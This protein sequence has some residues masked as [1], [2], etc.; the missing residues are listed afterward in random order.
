MKILELIY[1][2]ISERGEILFRETFFQYQLSVCN[3][4]ILLTDLRTDNGIINLYPGCTFIYTQL[5][6]KYS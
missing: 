2:L 5:Q 3:D 1:V 6:S 4:Y